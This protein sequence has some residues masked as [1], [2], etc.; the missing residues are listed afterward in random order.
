MSHLQTLYVFVLLTI[1]VS[2]GLRFGEVP[3]MINLLQPTSCAGTL[4]NGD[5]STPSLPPA[6]AIVYDPEVSPWIFTNGSSPSGITT[7]QGFLVNGTK[8]GQYAFMEGQNSAIAVC[9]DSIIGIYSVAWKNA[10]VLSENS[11]GESSTL[12][13]QVTSSDETMLVANAN[14]TVTMGS[15]FQMQTLYLA[16][17]TPGS[18]ILSFTIVSAS[19][20][21]VTL[22]DDV[23]WT[24]EPCVERIS[25]GGFSLPVLESNQEVVFPTNALPWIFVSDPGIPASRA[26][27]SGW[28]YFAVNGTASGQFAFLQGFGVTIGVCLNVTIPGIYGL[29]WLSAGRDQSQDQG[30]DATYEF[31]YYNEI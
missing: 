6:T 16:I 13:V 5:F 31:A 4:T 25:D 19:E 10:G 9:L 27:I 30:G 1:R 15:P 29:N 21:A 24:L 14:Y 7:P 12:M 28:D 26:G 22:I 3:T 18:Y 17:S 8:F 20:N 2:W 23:T 11:L